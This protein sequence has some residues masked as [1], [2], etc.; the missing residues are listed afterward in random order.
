MK[1]ISRTST[2]STSGVTFI[3][4]TT[5]GSSRSL[6]VI[7]MPYPAVSPDWLVVGV[8]VAMLLADHERHAGEAHLLGAGEELPHVAIRQ[9][10]VGPEDQPAK[11]I[12]GV[13][14]AEALDGA[15]EIVALVVDEVLAAVR[16]GDLEGVR[17]GGDVGIGVED[18][19]QVDL[20]VLLEPGRH[21]H[22]DDQQHEHDVDQRGDVDLGPD[23]ALRRLGELT[24]RHDDPPPGTPCPQPS[25]RS[26]SS[27]AASV[28]ASWSCEM[29][30]AR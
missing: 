8:V 14:A 6:A 25:M 9:V 21:H 11:R 17:H 2:T 13:R 26:V 16:H 29:R 24:A 22:E 10:L 20:H 18:P 5:A 27:P 4:G 30:V 15:V 19:G 23:A 3:W 7:A 28:S 12:G 1:M